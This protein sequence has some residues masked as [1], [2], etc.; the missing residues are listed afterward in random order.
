[1]V[2][3]DALTEMVLEKKFRLGVDVF[4]EEPLPP[5]HPIHGA[6]N[7]I[8]SSHRAGAIDDAFRNI[9]RIVTND[10]EAICRG[11][12]PREMQLAQPEFIV[13]RG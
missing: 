2:D 3:F 12:E 7:A 11:L 6:E 10:M 8:L 4:P 5:D 9:G 13:M 1:L